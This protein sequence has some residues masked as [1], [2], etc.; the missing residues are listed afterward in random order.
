MEDIADVLV[1]FRYSQL[2]LLILFVC[3]T[4]LY[5]IFIVRKK[6]FAKNRKYIIIIY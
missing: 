5:C 2:F 4:Y 3:I 6:T 1:A